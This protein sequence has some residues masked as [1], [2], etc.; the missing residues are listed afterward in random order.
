MRRAREVPQDYRR[1]LMA[2]YFFDLIENA[3]IERDETGV[4]FGNFADAR[5]EAARAVG[6]VMRELTPHSSRRNI[7]MKVRS[8]AGT[9]VHECV[10]DFNARDLTA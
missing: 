5:K 2:R 7:I 10:M 3:T 4:V 1:R 8:S 6:E 9:Y